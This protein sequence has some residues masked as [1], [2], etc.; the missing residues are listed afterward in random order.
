M[1]NEIVSLYV[2]NNPIQNI[3]I[4]KVNK[5]NEKIPGSNNMVVCF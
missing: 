4:M 1:M 2:Q 5:M 3:M